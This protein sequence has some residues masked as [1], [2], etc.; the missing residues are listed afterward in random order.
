MWTC[1]NVSASSVTMKAAVHLGIPW[2]V[3]CRF[4]GTL[5]GFIRK[6]DVV[7]VLWAATLVIDAMK[8]ER[9]HFAYCTSLFLW[10]EIDKSN[11]LR[12][13][14]RKYFLAERIGVTLPWFR[15]NSSRTF[16]SSSWDTLSPGL[17]FCNYTII[18]NYTTIQG[19]RFVPYTF[20]ETKP[21]MV[22]TDLNIGF[23]GLALIQGQIYNP[24]IYYM[25]Y[26]LYIQYI[27][28]TLWVLPFYHTGCTTWLIVDLQHHG[29]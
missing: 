2:A 28:A 17:V 26:T 12:S 10:G 5:K 11:F 14:R 27:C 22:P 6:T 19:C 18:I 24:A 20:S 7:E 8:F 9:W 3:L 25:I 16:A 29:T 4:V 13:L 21:Q 23:Q 1:D 15:P